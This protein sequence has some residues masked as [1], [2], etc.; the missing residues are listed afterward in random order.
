MQKHQYLLR[1]DARTPDEKKF[2]DRFFRLALPREVDYRGKMP[3]IWDQGNL[4]ACQSYAIDAI[5]AFIKKLAFTPSHIFTYFNT[6]YVEGSPAYEDTG[7]TLKGTCEAV[8]DYGIC[9][10]EIWPNDN[11]RFAEKPSDAAYAD[12]KA[13]NDSILDFLPCGNHRRGAAGAG[14][15]ALYRH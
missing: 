12:G 1:P 8:K 15:S 9:N 11:S 7:G 14:P 2:S 3:P 5:V 6:R 4:G 13:G 10:A